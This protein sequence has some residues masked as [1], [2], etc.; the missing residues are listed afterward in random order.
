MVPKEPPSSQ[1]VILCLRPSVPDQTHHC[2]FPARI[3][4]CTYFNFSPC[5]LPG[6]CCPVHTHTHTHTH[7]VGGKVCP[8]CV[9]TTPENCQKPQQRTVIIHSSQIFSPPLSV[10]LSLRLFLSLTQTHV[11]FT[12]LFVATKQ[13]IPLQNPIY[14]KPN[15]NLY[16]KSNQM[17]FVTC[18]VNNRCRLPVKCLLTGPSQQCREKHMNIIE[19]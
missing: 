14:P 5:P 1:C 19:R 11:C 12:I 17:L 15:P 8:V 9:R 6:M 4:S 13:L 7:G 10:P 3:Y 2:S 18:L 16:P